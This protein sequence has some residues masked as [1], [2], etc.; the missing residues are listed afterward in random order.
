M[1]EHVLQVRGYE[2][3]R[4]RLRATY[5]LGG[6]NSGSADASFRVLPAHITIKDQSNDSE[7]ATEAESTSEKD[8]DELVDLT[9]KNNDILLGTGIGLGVLLLVIAVA[10]IYR[11]YM[12]DS[13]WGA[14]ISPNRGKYV[15]VG[16]FDSAMKY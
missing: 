12:R 3:R 2:D 5:V 1:H 13:N 14:D 15:S 9:E 6:K 11:V 8:V 4:R 7:E 16:R 10:V